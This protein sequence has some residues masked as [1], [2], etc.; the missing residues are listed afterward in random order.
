MRESSMTQIVLL[1]AFALSL[2]TGVAT[3][4]IGAF[5][6]RYSVKDAS[7]LA[8]LLPTRSINED[9]NE[10]RELNRRKARNEMLLLLGVRSV[11][12][13]AVVLFG[14]GF[15]VWICCKFLPIFRI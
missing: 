9:T 5:L 10:M 7:D 3:M 14:A 2:A 8:S 15:L 12:G 4:G 11:P 1:I 13:F 6:L